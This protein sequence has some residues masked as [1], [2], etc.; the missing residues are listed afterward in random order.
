M[1]MLHVL[2]KSP[3][4]TRTLESCLAHIGDGSAILLIEDGIYAAMRGTPIEAKISGAMGKTAVYALGPDLDAR[5]MTHDKVVSG[6][7]IVDY[8]GFVDLAAKHD[9]VHSWL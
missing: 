8:A 5:G 9:S 1:S 6:I 4:H 2:N 7:K 3:F